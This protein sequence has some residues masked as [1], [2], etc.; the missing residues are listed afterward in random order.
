V[1][2]VGEETYMLGSNWPHA[3][4]VADPMAQAQ[5]AVSGLVEPA[6]ANMLGANAAWFLG[7]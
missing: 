5:R 4:G 6:R 1:P 3:E 7:L 2:N